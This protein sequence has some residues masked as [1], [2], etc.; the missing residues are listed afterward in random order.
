MKYK[1]KDKT[2]HYMR[3]AP[4]TFCF[5][6]PQTCFNNTLLGY[7]SFTENY[8]EEHNV[9]AVC[10]LSEI[11]LNDMVVKRFLKQL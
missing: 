7:L 5:V 2:D 3:F 8:L 11:F 4:S 1:L 10:Y 6:I 9:C